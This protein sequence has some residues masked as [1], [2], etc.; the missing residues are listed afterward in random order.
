MAPH[1]SVPEMPSWPGRN[2]LHQ[3]DEQ[4][5]RGLRKVHQEKLSRYEDILAGTSVAAAGGWVLHAITLGASLA[6]VAAAAAAVT[7]NICKCRERIELIERTMT[8]K[9]Y[10][11]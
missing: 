10:T 9:G 11:F 6:L 4:Y 2:Y 7:A 5:L 1:Y 3:Y 8:S